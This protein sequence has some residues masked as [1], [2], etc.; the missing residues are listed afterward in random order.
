[1]LALLPSTTIPPAISCSPPPPQLLPSHHS[2]RSWLDESS[3]KWA[4]LARNAAAF[5]HEHG[6]PP[7][8]WLDLA[9]ASSIHDYRGQASAMPIY[10][11]GCQK[12]LCLCG[13]SYP[14]R[15]WPIMEMY[16][17]QLSPITNPRAQL[18]PPTAV[19]DMRCPPPRGGHA[20]PSSLLLRPEGSPASAPFAQ[21]LTTGFSPSFSWFDSPRPAATASAGSA[22]AAP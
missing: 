11:H 1:M 13:Q 6:R 20:L 7:R 21:W 22:Q 4:A 16:A 9:C 19:V 8:I 15:L 14:E 2:S 12:L 3:S 5:A 18:Q 10:V 17:R